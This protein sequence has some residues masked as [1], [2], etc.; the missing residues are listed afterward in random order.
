MYRRFFQILNTGVIRK[1]IPSQ[2]LRAKEVEFFFF[3]KLKPLNKTWGR[4]VSQLKMRVQIAN[5]HFITQ[6][7]TSKNIPL[8]SKDSDGSLSH[9]PLLSL[10]KKSPL[11][12]NLQRR[13]KKNWGIPLT[14]ISKT[15]TFRQKFRITNQKKEV[16]TNPQQHEKCRKKMTAFRQT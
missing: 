8:G 3:T 6:R 12:Q 2:P 13:H 1:I 10:K 11:S 5:S 14:I 15:G 9:R 7:M 16:T 4:V